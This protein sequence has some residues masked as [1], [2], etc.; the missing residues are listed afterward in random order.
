[1]TQKNEPIF[2][3]L[4]FESCV[5]KQ[6][7]NWMHLFFWYFHIY[8]FTYAN[9][10]SICILKGNGKTKKETNRK[11]HI[12]YLEPRSRNADNMTIFF[13][14]EKFSW[15]FLNHS[16]GSCEVLYK[17]EQPIIQIFVSTTVRWYLRRF[18]LS[19]YKYLLW[20]HLHLR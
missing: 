3:L 19:F 12:N 16:G 9:K 13:W 8:S 7:C 20:L 18:L 1:M 15:T 11:W 10:L 4:I 14:K 2:Y 17:L 5:I 6:P